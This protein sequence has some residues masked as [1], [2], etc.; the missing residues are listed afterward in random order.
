MAQQR[1][2]IING[3][4]Q[5]I[6]YQLFPGCRYYENIAIQAGRVIHVWHAI[7]GGN[8]TMRER[9]ADWEHA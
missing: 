2:L 7:R 9:P 3:G 8:V 6:Q 4:P 1:F 5:R